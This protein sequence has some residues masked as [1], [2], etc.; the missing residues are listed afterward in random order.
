MDQLLPLA[1]VAPLLVAAGICALNPVLRSSGGC[2]TP[3][4]S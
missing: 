2:W 3:S 4:P 1:A